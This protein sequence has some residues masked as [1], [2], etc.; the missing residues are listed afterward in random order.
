MSQ[1]LALLQVFIPSDFSTRIAL[2]ERVKRS[3][4]FIAIPFAAWK[5]YP[6]Q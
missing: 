2:M 6:D 5:G 1:I 3:G 4:F